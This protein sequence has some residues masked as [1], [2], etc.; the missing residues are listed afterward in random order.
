MSL[1]DS[2]TPRLVVRLLGRFEVAVDGVAV[3]E[4][5]WGRR[6]ARSLVKILAL[7]PRHALHRE[8]LIDRLW[9]DLELATA[10]SSL[11]QAIH[12]VR[13]ALREVSPDAGDLLA[14]DGEMV[15]L[16]G[17][18]WVDAGAFEEA[19]R[20]AQR[21]R[22]RQAVEAAVALYT[23]ELLPEDRFDD[24][25]AVPR[26]AF[27]ETF[28]AL[29]V[30]LA[31]LCEAE[32][33][34]PAASEAL[35]RAV[36]VDPLHEDAHAA[37]MR[38]HARAGRTGQALRQY[39]RLRET[40]VREL[41][42]EPSAGTRGLHAEI[43]AGR[44]ASHDPA[45]APS[46]PTHNLAE[47]L[48]RFVGRRDDVAR[49]SSLLDTTRLLTL[50]G[51]GGAGKS[52]LAIEVARAIAA[53]FPGGVWLVELAALA[54]PALVPHAVADAI[55]IR[56]QPG[57]PIAHTLVAALASRQ[58]L[59]VLDN[60]EH[61]I[62]ACAGLAASLL[63]AGPASRI[64]ATSREPLRV[65]GEVVYRV[66]PLAV[67][68]ASAVT[69][70]LLDGV[71]AVELFVDRVRWVRPGFV[72]TDANAAAVARVCQRLDGLPLAL[73]L[74]AARAS[75]LDPAQIAARLDDALGVLSAGSR[76]APGRQRTMQATLD[77]SHALLG[78]GERA[79]LRRLSVFA[80][81]WTIEAAEEVCAGDGIEP[82]AVLPS[83]ADLV[84]KSLVQVEDAPAGDAVEVR[85]RLLE[86]VR[87]YAA[88]QLAASGEGDAVTAR[89]AEWCTALATQAEPAYTGPDQAV[90]LDR[91][92][93]E[94]DNVRAALRW[95][96]GRG[97]VV[98]EARLLSVVWRFW[99]YRSHLVEGDRWLGDVLQRLSD[100]VPPAVRA[101]VL[102]GAGVIAWNAGD[103]E[104]SARM[105]RQSLVLHQQTGDLAGISATTQALGV[106][107]EL[108]GRYDEA[109]RYYRESLRL[110][111]K[112]G[113][114]A[115]A[116][117]T[118]QNLGNMAREQ[119]RLDEA[120][121]LYERSL[122]IHKRLGNSRGVALALASLAV[123]ALDRGDY[124]A[125]AD[126][127]ARGVAIYQSLGATSLQVTA[128]NNLGIATM[129]MGDA[130]RA[131][132]IQ[133]DTLR[134]AVEFGDRR[135][136]AY[137]LEGVAAALALLPQHADRAARLFGAAAS[138][139]EAI[140]V[141]LPPADAAL[142]ERS[143]A[144]LRATL[145]EAAVRAAWDAGRALP[146]DAAVAE[147]FA[148]RDTLPSGSDAQPPTQPL[149]PR[150]R[151]V[152][153][154]VAAGYTNREIA[155]RLGMARRTVDTHV[156]N[157]LRKLG[158]ASRAEVADWVRE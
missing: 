23:G 61:L 4:G 62:D 93:R 81:G 94:H 51:P 70:A 19:A 8:E 80:G 126:L 34:L 76:T 85:Y 79:L 55:G 11:R 26:E 74:A 58:A 124:R 102:Q 72:L 50:T 44:L 91:M 38:L 89:H 104:R 67:P 95:L 101:R 32:G 57:T 146:A 42:V 133:L 59:I 140:A 20:V 28:T 45:V 54:D 98:G 137:G 149:S 82:S 22:E 75:A 60:C 110:R 63:A 17:P 6:K 29:L 64:L 129:L 68:G 69:A 115:G 151:E 154:L 7:S 35:D 141:P 97:D 131:V 48:S 65:P 9:P 78:P 108:Q 120:G 46:A 16:R 127:S 37:L 148:A 150:E 116:A 12:I 156:S 31:A 10:G 125:S 144:A 128:V 152:A 56:E 114:D 5:A 100:D 53:R 158:L 52:R 132:E 39:A 107:D 118:L 117:I 121:D 119:G 111:E 113:D 15:G 142:Y 14:V 88:A 99:Y 3:P 73:E 92:E 2:T 112:L 13:R 77:W 122:A 139:R 105:T 106:V 155:E 96:A 86:T 130:A 157:V 145:D 36:A 123:V 135:G 66:L 1:P 147:A 103:P 33:D 84:D 27:R 49:T 71:E 30:E 153:A 25:A 18:V 21:R 24:W 83:L 134:L 138:L 143:L 90:W 43:A 109:T 47:P 41:D 40:L 136:I 87:Q